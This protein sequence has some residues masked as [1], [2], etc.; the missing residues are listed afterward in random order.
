MML[1]GTASI[2]PLTSVAPGN[3][4]FTSSFGWKVADPFVSEVVS[5]LV[6]PGSVP[7]MNSLVFR[8]CDRTAALLRQVVLNLGATNAGCQC[9]CNMDGLENPDA[10]VSIEAYHNISRMVDNVLIDV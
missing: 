1:D 5:L 6:S 2:S 10:D 7:V 8:R 9:S 3:N 4:A